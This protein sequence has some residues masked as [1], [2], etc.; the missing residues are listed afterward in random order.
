MRRY[1]VGTISGLFPV[2]QLNDLLIGCLK[3]VKITGPTAVFWERFVLKQFIYVLKIWS[4][5]CQCFCSRIFKEKMG[6]ILK[7]NCAIKVPLSLINT[8]M[9]CLK[10]SLPSLSPSGSRRSQPSNSSSPTQCFVPDPSFSR[11]PLGAYRSLWTG[12]QSCWL[13]PF[14]YPSP[15]PNPIPQSQ[16]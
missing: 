4:W 15:P 11:Q 14:S 13:Q 5:D 16:P 10:G 1:D 12:K 6:L 3:M 2:K 9:L 7:K 8:C